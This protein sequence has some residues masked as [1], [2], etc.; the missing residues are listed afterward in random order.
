MKVNKYFIYILYILFLLEFK[1]NWSNYIFCLS[2]TKIAGVFL[3]VLV[4]SASAWPFSLFGDEEKKE[5]KSDVIL[6][7]DAGD[8]KH[9]QTGKPGEKVHGIFR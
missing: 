3:L 5:E 9:I 2:Q 6:N 7:Y 1:R 4:A 8:H